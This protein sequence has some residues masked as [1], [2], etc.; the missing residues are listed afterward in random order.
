MSQD[1]FRFMCTMAFIFS[2]KAEA[3]VFK[4]TIIQQCF[5]PY[6]IPCQV[7]MSCHGRAGY[8]CIVFLHLTQWDRNF[9]HQLSQTWR[10]P[11]MWGLYR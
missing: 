5:V 9:L 7:I 4:E 3:T 1:A 8:F 10:L 11:Y 6:A 2:A